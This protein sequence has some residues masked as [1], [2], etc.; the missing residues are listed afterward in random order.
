MGVDFY[1]QKVWQGFLVIIKIVIITIA[2]LMQ[3]NQ[4]PKLGMKSQKDL[5]GQGYRHLSF[6]VHYYFFL[7]LFLPP[8]TSFFCLLLILIIIILPFLK[9]AQDSVF[10]SPHYTHN[11]ILT[12]TL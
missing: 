6:I 12:I 5:P 3:W 10:V 7:F 9:E 4:L 8:S 2:P 11:V 1:I